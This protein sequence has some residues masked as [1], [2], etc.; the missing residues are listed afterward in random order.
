MKSK[1][2]LWRFISLM[3]EVLWAI[4]VIFMFTMITSNFGSMKKRFTFEIEE[5]KT[6][7]CFDCPFNS[8]GEFCGMFPYIDCEEYNMYTLKLVEDGK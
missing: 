1:I 7:S 8:G 5:G 6:P 2:N 4:S 3:M